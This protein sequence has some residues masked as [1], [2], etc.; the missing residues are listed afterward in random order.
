MGKPGEAESGE[1]AFT[2]RAVKDGAVRIAYR[3]K[4][5]T[6]LAGND[7][8]R[9]LARIDVADADQAQRIMAK[10]TGNF[11]HGNERRSRD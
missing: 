2:F 4:V 10:A 1:D 5:V 3:G 9:F 11:K 7:A 8:S 6:T